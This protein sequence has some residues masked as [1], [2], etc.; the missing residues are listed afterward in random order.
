[1]DSLPPVY[2]GL[3]R[4]AT[5]ASTTVGERQRSGHPAR[6]PSSQAVWHRNAAQWSHVGAPLRPGPH[7]TAFS[8]GAMAAWEARNGSDS[9]VVAVLG[10]TPELCRLS[11][12]AS[13]RFTAIDKSADM[14]RSNWRT[15][16][17]P[18]GTVICADWLSMPCPPASIDL[19]LGDGSLSVLSYPDGYLRLGRELQRLLRANGQCI[20]RCFVR[21]DTAETPERIFEDLLDGRIGNFHVLKWRLAMA[22]QPGIQEGIAVGLVWSALNREWPDLAALAARC[23]WPLDEVRTIEAYL[24]IDTRYTFPTMAEYRQVLAEAGF[25][26]RNVCVPA[27]E[28]GDRCPTIVLES[29]ARA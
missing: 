10:V 29:T 1:M 22:L 14:I 20:I 27:Y 11:A 7:D 12:A 4:R 17:C 24:G 6:G 18:N 26:I 16:D 19:V 3:R 2:S 25:T 23:R 9:P 13:G 5:A 21:P 15:A 8:L 28:L